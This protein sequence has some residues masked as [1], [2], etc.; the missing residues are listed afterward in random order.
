VWTTQQARNLV[1]DLGER[2]ASFRFLI[3]DR[4]PARDVPHVVDMATDLTAPDL[5]SR[6]EFALDRLLDGV[7]TLRTASG[8]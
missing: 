5:D 7:D 3:R 6:F 4:D 8:P 2:T 1:M